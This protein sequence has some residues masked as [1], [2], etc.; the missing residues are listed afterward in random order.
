MYQL[1]YSI[2]I[3]MLLAGCAVQHETIN[4]PEKN[5]QVVVQ[6]KKETKNVDSEKNISP[7]RQHWKECQTLNIK[8]P[9]RMNLSAKWDWDKR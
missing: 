4:L 9:F 2:V 3:T 7:E 5:E 6:D 8:E 1:I